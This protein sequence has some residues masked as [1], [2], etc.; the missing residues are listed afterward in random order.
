MMKLF[1]L[2]FLCYKIGSAEAWMDL[3]SI[4]ITYGGMERHP[5]L[6]MYVIYIFVCVFFLLRQIHFSLDG[7][8]KVDL[9]EK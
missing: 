1:K 2:S 6:F 8:L 5:E 3:A 4:W 7:I 9:V